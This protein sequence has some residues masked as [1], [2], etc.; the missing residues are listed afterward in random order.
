MAEQ[1]DQNWFETLAGRKAA[2]A[3]SAT[4]KE[5][6][7]VRRAVLAREIDQD[8]PGFDV[9]SGTQKLLFALRREGLSGATLRRKSWQIYGAF[10]LAATLILAIGVVLLQPPVVEDIPVYRGAGA[11]TINTPDPAKLAATLTADLEAL[12]IQSKTTRFGA[13]FTITAIW[14]EKPEAGHLAFLKRHNLK[15]PAGGTL[16]IELSQI[17]S[18]R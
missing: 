9:E 17:E 1:D 11:Q 4:E 3:D 10:A 16:E 12:G 14:P 6:Q 8:L 7:A 13:T 18:R 2:N 5:A 15:Q